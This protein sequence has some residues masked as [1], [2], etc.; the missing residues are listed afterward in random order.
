MALDL[1]VKSS[2]S[3]TSDN[4][5]NIEQSAKAQMLHSFLLIK[6]FGYTCSREDPLLMIVCS[7]QL[8]SLLTLHSNSGSDYTR[9][10]TKKKDYRRLVKR[11]S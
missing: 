7:G 8:T 5:Q 3:A 9:K 10:G 4:G 6:H 1:A 2:V 11:A